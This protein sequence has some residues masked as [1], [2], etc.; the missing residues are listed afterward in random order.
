MMK[1]LFVFKNQNILIHAISKMEAMDIINKK[2][3]G[4]LE[5]DFQ[6]LTIS[7]ELNNK[8]EM[9]KEEGE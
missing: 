6:I 7:V 3:N 4:I 1:Y 9:V 5:D 2:Y 8:S